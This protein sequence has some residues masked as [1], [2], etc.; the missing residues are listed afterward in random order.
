[1]S[2]GASPGERGQTGFLGLAKQGGIT[3]R[4]D[5]DDPWARLPDD[6]ALHRVRFS[7]TPRWEA[8]TVTTSHGGIIWC[9]RRLADGALT[10]AGGPGQLLQHIAEADENLLHDQR[11]WS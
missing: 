2:T 7:V 4:D 3:L 5:S 9:A 1:M 6:E 8:W 11:G 10:H